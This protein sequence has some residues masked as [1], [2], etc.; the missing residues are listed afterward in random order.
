MIEIKHRYHCLANRGK[1]DDPQLVPP[2]MVRP[3]VAAWI[4]QPYDL[5]RRR[6][7]DLRPIRFSEVTARTGQ[8]EI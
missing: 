7:D 2:K 3:I 4:K 5:A 6:I 8:G 1:A